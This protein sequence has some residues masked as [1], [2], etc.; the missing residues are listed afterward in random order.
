MQAKYLIILGMVFAIPVLYGQDAPSLGDAARRIRAE[1]EKDKGPATAPSSSAS[2][3]ANNPAVQ[4]TPQPTAS[5]PVAVRPTDMTSDVPTRLRVAAHLPLHFVEPYQD[6]FRYFLDQED[7][8][9]L[10]EIADKAR[11]PQIR[12]PGGYWKLHILYDALKGPH[13]GTQASETEWTT[14]LDRLKRWVAQRPQ[15]V[16]ARV[17]LAGAYLRYGWRARG[18]GFA[19][20]VTAE[21]WKH[22]AERAEMAGQT[23]VDAFALPTKDPEW[24]LV[25]QGVA[26]ALGKDKSA[27]NAIFEKAV[28]F[29]PDY[30]YYYRFQAEMLMPKWDGE[31][32]EMAAFAERAAD[33]L[34]GKKGDEIYYQIATFV[35]CGCESDNNL[36]GMSWPRIKRGY[37]VVKEQYGETLD[38][39]NKM[40]AMAG[41]AGDPA[42]AMEL[43]DRI[44]ENWDPAVWQNEK[45]FQGVRAWAKWSVQTLT[46]EAAFKAAND[47][48]QTPDG[49]NFDKQV[50]KIFAANYGDTLSECVKA[51]GG[52][53]LMP[54]DLA[55]RVGNSGAV[56]EVYASVV[57]DASSCVGAKVKTG[58]FPAPPRPSYWVKVH[59]QEQK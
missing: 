25:M 57:M 31:E 5:Q 58:T 37:Q 49:R 4:V 9:K 23:L 17:A 16:T 53:L 7:F 55:M 36:N 8:E 20:Q 18:E 32:G 39:M 12:Y 40:G 30:Q 26:Q 46:V 14:H 56:E 41:A 28:A 50:A 47:N 52:T 42:F 44:G 48:L 21:G 13:R 15:S 22:F 51:S 35:N 59:F 38:N 1:K 24:Y 19:N 3:T 11:R 33:R 34:G 6:G 54:F 2:T 10:D 43:F 45:S 29:E 27:Q